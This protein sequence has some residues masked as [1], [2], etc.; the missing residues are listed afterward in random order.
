MTHIEPGPMPAPEP[1]P[2]EIAASTKPR[3]RLSRAAHAT[4]SWLDE[5]LGLKK[6]IWPIII[7]PVPKSTNWWYV[8][9]SATLVAFIMQVITGVALAF[10]Y[11]PSPDAAYESVRWISED[12]VLGSVVRGVH[13]WGA[14]AMVILIFLHMCRTFAFGSFKYPRELSWLTGVVLLLLTIGLAFTGQLLRWDQDAY[15]AVFV[16]AEQAARVPVVGNWIMQIMLAGET[17]GGNT[18]TRFYATHVFLLPALLFAVVGIHLYMV[19]KHGIS[20][21]PVKGEKVDP[22]TYQA[23]YEEI[24]EKKG[25]PFWPDAAWKDV[26]FAL[27]IGTVVLALAIWP[28]PKALGEVADPTILRAHPKPDWYFLSLFALLALMPAGMEDFLIVVGPLLMGVLLFAVPFISNK[29]ERH[30][31]RRPWALGIIGFAV[32]SLTVLT[33]LG[34]AAPWSPELSEDLALPDDVAAAAQAAGLERGATIFEQNGCLN[35][36]AVRGTGGQRGPDLTTIGDQLSHDE[37]TWRVLYGGNGM[38]PYGGT[39]SAQDAAAVVAFL[40][41]QRAEHGHEATP[42]P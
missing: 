6:T 4:F 18:L 9:G 28:G 2:T 33:Y 10:T 40:E 25:M 42:Q 35:C 24:L 11:V 37:L 15:W 36:H 1:D 23:R 30:P 19:V 22:K 31:A 17:V 20:E 39:L 14:S 3:G 12:A 27:A 38:P 13:Y 29:G 8:L 41:Q 7:H 34:G 21:V 32:I 16:G 26:A 5:R